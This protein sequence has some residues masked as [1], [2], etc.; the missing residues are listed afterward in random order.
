MGMEFGVEKC[1]I[2]IM[3]C[4]KRKITEGI[5]PPNQERISTVEESQNYEY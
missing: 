3:K 1:T 5:E 4:E 2:L